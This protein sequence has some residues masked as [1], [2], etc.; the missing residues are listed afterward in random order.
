MS[1]PVWSSIESSSQLYVLNS[2]RTCSAN[3]AATRPF[4]G[5]T[6]T[7]TQVVSDSGSAQWDR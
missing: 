3:S 5:T 4:R 6:L 1:N 7:A 2:P